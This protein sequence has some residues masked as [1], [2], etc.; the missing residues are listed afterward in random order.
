MTEPTEKQKKA[1][2]AVKIL[3]PP[4]MKKVVKR[5]ATAVAG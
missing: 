4:R 3:L 5:R 2:P 1:E